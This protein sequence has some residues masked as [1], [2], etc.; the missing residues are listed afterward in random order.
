MYPGATAYL[1]QYKD[2]LKKRQSD[3]SAKW[4]EYGRSQA[5]GSLNSEK[6]LISTVVTNEV[7]VYELDADCIPYS[8]MYIVAKEKDYEHTLEEAIRIWKS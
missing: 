8:G 7:E 3:R 6:L 4:Y 2:D 5:L 1:K